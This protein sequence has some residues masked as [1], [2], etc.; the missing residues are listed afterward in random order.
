M[1]FSG[2]LHSLRANVALCLGR[3]VQMLPG[4]WLSDTCL[5]RHTWAATSD[6]SGVSATAPPRTL[7]VRL[8]RALVSDADTGPA[9][10]VLSRGSC[11]QL[12]CQS[13][14]SGSDPEQGTAGEHD[15]VAWKRK[16][17]LSKQSAAACAGAQHQLLTWDQAN[18]SCQRQQKTTLDSWAA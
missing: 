14:N 16:A 7:A 17:V 13:T 9:G 18:S 6:I 11:L 5:Y 8:I 15:A 1:S 10:A 12:T 3:H 2:C 4:P